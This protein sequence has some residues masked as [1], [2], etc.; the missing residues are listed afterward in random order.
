M[1]CTRPCCSSTNWQAGIAK[2]RLVG[3]LCRILLDDEEIA[4]R[5]Y[6]EE[7]GYEVLAGSIPESA[8][9]RIAQNKGQSLTETAE[10]S[11]NERADALIEAL[12]AKIGYALAEAEDH[13]QEERRR[14]MTGKDTARRLREKFRMG[15]PPLAGDTK[16]N[17]TSPIAGAHRGG[18]KRKAERMAQLNLRVPEEVKA[19]VRILAARDRIEMSDVV[20]EAIELYEEKYGAA[21]KLEPSRRTPA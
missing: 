8:S 2:S 12:L 9:Y 15:S 17:L 6:L 7:A 19:R 1:T 5:S 21:P 11:L 16:G 10:R 20:M 4:A 14:R 3:A 13:H 18:R